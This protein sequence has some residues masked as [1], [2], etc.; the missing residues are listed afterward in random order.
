MSTPKIR[1]EQLRQLLLDM[2]FSQTT[3]QKSHVFFAHA[4]SGAEF[5]LP[6]Y[7][8]NQ[9]VLPHHLVTVRVMLDGKG[10]LDAGAFDDFV[11]AAATTKQSAS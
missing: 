4:S 8:A 11:A 3:T 10:L 9:I 7:R 6:I 2:G 5:A 1:F